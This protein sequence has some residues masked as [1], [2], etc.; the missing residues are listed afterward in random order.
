MERLPVE[1]IDAIFADL[2][3]RDA[4]SLRVVSKE[5]AA[6]GARY[7]HRKLCIHISPGH[8]DKVANIAGTP[9]LA[10][11]VHHL[12]IDTGRMDIAFI[13]EWKYYSEYYRS[14]VAHNI[15][16]SFR[17]SEKD[18]RNEFDRTAVYHKRVQELWGRNLRQTLQT[19][20]QS[21]PSLKKLEISDETMQVGASRP[22]QTRSTREVIMAVNGLTLKD[23]TYLK[24]GHRE[25]CNSLF[26]VG[27]CL[28]ASLE[29]LSMR[30]IGHPKIVLPQNPNL[31]QSVRTL[32]LQLHLDS[33]YRLP[34]TSFV[35]LENL[36]LVGI[37]R[38]WSNYGLLKSFPLSSTDGSIMPRLKQL[39]LEYGRHS[40]RDFLGFL[41]R[42][43]DSL[44][45]IRLHRTIIED[46]QWHYLYAYNIRKLGSEEI[47]VVGGFDD[48][49]WEGGMHQDTEDWHP[50][51]W[52]GAEAASRTIKESVYD[53]MRAIDEDEIETI[54]KEE[55]DDLISAMPFKRLHIGY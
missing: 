38:P 20:L 43:K 36:T 48:D 10:S 18:V 29:T 50:F 15:D 22:W 47:L 54:S 45:C 12:V 1:I 3:Q 27:G 34:Y 6:V 25:I 49:T 28:P 51:S 19:I 42:H 35:N 46:Q 13:A 26:K 16:E 24:K 11:N 21:F 41:N 33:D 23:S 37:P 14:A 4:T 30:C 55:S 40:E 7:S 44:E 32:E 31:L 52:E 39:R 17:I 53:Y 9:H 5:A 8:V 2:P